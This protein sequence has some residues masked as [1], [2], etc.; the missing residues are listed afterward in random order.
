[1]SLFDK[2][3]L[4]ENDYFKTSRDVW[5]KT[6]DEVYINKV[7]HVCKYTIEKES[8]IEDDTVFISTSLCG[9]PL[10]LVLHLDKEVTITEFNEDHNNVII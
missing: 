6:F 2:L 7:N 10:I 1:M 3:S 9:E 5:A 8:F 4:I